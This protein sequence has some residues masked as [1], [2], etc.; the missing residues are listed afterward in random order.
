MSNTLYNNALYHL[1][2]EANLKQKDN[3]RCLYVR[4]FLEQYQCREHAN[5][6]ILMT[7]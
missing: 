3:Y 5:E 1:L 6:R 2:K 4:W 7:E